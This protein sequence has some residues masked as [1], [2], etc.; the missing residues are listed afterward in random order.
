MRT[1]G[2][3]SN[4]SV[5]WQDL[6]ALIPADYEG[7]ITVG[8]KWLDAFHAPDE[9]T[10]QISKDEYERLKSGDTG[11]AIEMKRASVA[12]VNSVKPKFTIEE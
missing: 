1:P 3:V 5:K 9:N 4:I 10:V 6:Q 2:A 12:P 8:K 11:E 7:F